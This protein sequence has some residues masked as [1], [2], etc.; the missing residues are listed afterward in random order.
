MPWCVYTGA[1]YYRNYFLTN[2]PNT[3]SK[4]QN[5]TISCN[6][7]G[8]VISYGDVNKHQFIKYENTYVKKVQLYGTVKYQKIQNDGFSPIQEKLYS[9]VVYGFK[10]FTQNEISRM[11]EQTVIDI[12]IKYTKAHRILS[13][14]KQDL[15][16]SN[17]DHFLVSLFPKSSV[18]KAFVNT[19]GYIDENEISDEEYLGFKDLGINKQGIAN[20]LIEYSLLPQNFYELV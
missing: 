14:W 15:I 18:T 8:M 16:F 7:Q 4:N 11:S 5:K 6:S 13:R 12:K 2:K 20:K 3:M 17:V 19:K 1:F 9:Q 10:A